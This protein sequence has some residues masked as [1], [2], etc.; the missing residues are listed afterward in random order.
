MVQNQESNGHDVRVRI[1]YLGPAGTYGHQVC[2]SINCPLARAIPDTTQAAKRFLLTIDE[3]A[4]D[5]EL[6]P[7]PTIPGKLHL[8]VSSAF[9]T[10]W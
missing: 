7:C 9:L 10:F 1:A 5:V 8:L 3:E 2:T 4:K 6:I